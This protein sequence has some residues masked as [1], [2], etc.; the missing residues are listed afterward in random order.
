M[1]YKKCY[2]DTYIFYHILKTFYDKNKY[3]CI[4]Q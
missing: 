1:Q 2:I 4:D 3:L